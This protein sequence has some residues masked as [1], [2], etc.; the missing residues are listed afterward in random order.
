[1]IEF[2]YKSDF[3]IQE[4]KKYINWVRAIIISEQK[5]CGDIS[6]TFCTDADLDKI[7]QE[8]L[9]HTD[10]TDIISFDY[11]IGTIISGDIFISTDR[12]KDNAAK[13]GVSFAEEILRVMAHGILHFCGYKD[14]SEAEKKEMRTKEE[15]KIKL[16]HVEQSKK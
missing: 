6:Y 5:K 4:E 10:Y 1:M 16:F 15:E 7:N 13:F 2:I 8:Y 12:V 11:V 9:N 3:K 14:F